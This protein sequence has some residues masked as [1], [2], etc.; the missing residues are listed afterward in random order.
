MAVTTARV[1][2]WWDYP[3][4]V[5]L[6][7]SSAYA[8]F[9]LLSHWFSVADVLHHPISFP[10]MTVILVVVLTNNQGRWFLLPFMRKPRTIAPPP[11]RKVAV[12]TTFVPDGEPFEMLKATVKAL[13]A[14]DYPHDTWVLDEGDSDRVKA[15]CLR[16]GARH[17]SRKGLPQ[18]Q[19]PSGAFQSGSKHGT[20]NA[21]LH[22]GD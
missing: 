16:L 9:A 13:I 21:W 10:V 12:A 7:I 15:L 1:L 3:I 6:S 4:F 14:L 11:D 19:A 5:F 17:F 18:Y 20:Y 8:I 22:E 2:K